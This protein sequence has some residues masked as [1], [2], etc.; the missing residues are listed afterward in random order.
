MRGDDNHVLGG[1]ADTIGFMDDRVQ[2]HHRATIRRITALHDALDAAIRAARRLAAEAP[3]SEVFEQAL[4]TVHATHAELD[5]QRRL[6]RALNAMLPTPSVRLV[7]PTPVR[8]PTPRPHRAR[9][10]ARVMQ[11]PATSA[12]WAQAPLPTQRVPRLADRQWPEPGGSEPGFS[13]PGGSEPGGSEAGFS[14]AR[15]PASVRHESQSPETQDLTG[16]DRGSR[17]A[18][19]RAGAPSATRWEGGAVR[20]VRSVGGG[21]GSTSEETRPAG[22]PPMPRPRFT[23]PAR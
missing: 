14:D 8:F 9:S 11:L 2:Q 13:E 4:A 21:C 17:E 20:S 3:G 10:F 5:A 22:T 18:R 1:Y 23:P 19:L 12:P 6:A 7:P 16:E 15:L